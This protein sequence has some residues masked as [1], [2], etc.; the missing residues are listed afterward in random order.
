RRAA[1]PTPG[2]RTAARSPLTT[3]AASSHSHRQAHRKQDHDGSSAA[4]DARAFTPPGHLQ[5]EPRRDLAQRSNLN[6]KAGPIRLSHNLT[7]PAQRPSRLARSNETGQR[8]ALRVG[9]SE[10]PATT[11]ARVQS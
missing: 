3:T 7:Y 9:P 10:A 4:T 5:R 11:S 6:E 1:T 2:G 8:P